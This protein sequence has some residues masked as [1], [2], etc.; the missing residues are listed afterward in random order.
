MEHCEDV[1]RNETVTG[2]WLQNS[3]NI[4]IVIIV[5]EEHT[6]FIT[7]LPFCAAWENQRRLLPRLLSHYLSISLYSKYR[8]WNL[9]IIAKLY[10][11][12]KEG[13]W[14]PTYL[15]MRWYCV[16]RCYH[17]CLLG[18][19]GAADGVM[20]YYVRFFS[21][22]KLQKVVDLCK[23]TVIALR[24]SIIIYYICTHYT[25]HY[26]LLECVKIGHTD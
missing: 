19:V 10:G 11:Y 20:N 12:V 6:S 25:K 9:I 4:V 18:R 15:M 13:V 16:G 24:G 1:S 23:K 5:V 22:S 14:I 8:L 2:R 17:C 26:T 21:T 3:N 7:R